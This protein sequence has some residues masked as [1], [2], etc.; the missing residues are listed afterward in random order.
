G[1]R[2]DRGPRWAP[3]GHRGTARPVAARSADHPPV[4][5]AEPRGVGPREGCY[6]L[7]PS[8]ASPSLPSQWFVGPTLSGVRLVGRRTLVV[9]GRQHAG[10][11]MRRR[12]CSDAARLLR[13]ADAP[14]KL[15]ELPEL[16]GKQEGRDLWRRLPGMKRFGAEGS[17]ET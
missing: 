15:L 14:L 4:A 16:A 7:P 12:S 13:A 3:H 8:C 1:L 5:G 2:G 6:R 9:T 10:T 11:A 17:R